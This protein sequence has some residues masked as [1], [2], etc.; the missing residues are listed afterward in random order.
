MELLSSFTMTNITGFLW[1][2]RCLLVLHFTLV[3]TW[4]HEGWPLGPG[5]V[6]KYICS[7]LW[8]FLCFLKCFPVCP[9]WRHCCGSRGCFSMSSANFFASSQLLFWRQY[10][11]V[12]TSEQQCCL[13]AR[14]L[15]V[16]TSQ[17]RIYS[18]RRPGR[19]LKIWALKGG[20]FIR[21]AFIS[22]GRLFQNLIFQPQK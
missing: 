14:S 11:F 13:I 2:F 5:Q 21:E 8:Y 16:Y 4:T 17:Y 22:E 20:A 18:N 19:L 1:A 10:F 15:A 3:V 7:N 12:S 9:P 6:R